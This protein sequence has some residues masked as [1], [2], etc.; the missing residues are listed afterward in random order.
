M[1]TL[2]LAVVL[3]LAVALG[4]TSDKPTGDLPALHPVKGKVVR[5][6]TPV[7]GGSVRFHPDPE[8]LDLVVG[9]EVQSDGSFELHTQHAQSQ[10]KAKGA[11]AGTYQVTYYP[12]AGDQTQGPSPEPVSPT[13]P[14]TIQAGSNDLTVELGRK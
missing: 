11:P 10:K 13:Q 8:D 4:C 3:G 2:R 9:G 1:R 7:N 14:Q 5:G 12:P 6:G